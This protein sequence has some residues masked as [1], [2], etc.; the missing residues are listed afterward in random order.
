MGEK[1][2]ESTKSVQARALR[3]LKT[4]D[5]KIIW[6]LVFGTVTL[7]MVFPIPMPMRTSEDTLKLYRRVESSPPN[8]VVW[9]SIDFG[10][11]SLPGLQG[12]M[13]AMINHF[14]DKDIKIVFYCNGVAQQAIL[15]ST[16]WPT[17][18]PKQHAVLRY[19][20]DYVILPFVPGDVVAIAS[21]AKDIRSVCPSD[22]YGTPL[23][24]LPLMATGG[25]GGKPINDYSS[26]S[27]LVT[28]ETAWGNYVPQWKIPYGVD[29]VYFGTKVYTPAVMPAYSAGLMFTVIEDMKGGA[30]YELLSGYLGPSTKQIV[31]QSLP[32]VL[33][34][35]L[36]V[37]GNASYFHSR[38]K[39]GQ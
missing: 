6:L 29:I 34:I 3:F 1:V 19:G 4:Y 7:P 31:S 30:E 32:H 24:K 15:T 14:F 39:R 23:D 11:I 13:S 20:V 8:T 12:G 36:T 5:V 10:V 38:Y 2:E 26:F 22:I 35:V 16:M 28:S 18:A 9:F 21:L 33:L 17:I 37:L 25:K 27:W